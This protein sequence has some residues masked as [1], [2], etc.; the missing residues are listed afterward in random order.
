[1]QE[2]RG[3]KMPYI[4]LDKSIITSSLWLDTDATLLFIT[5]LILADLHEL[6]EP[7]PQLEINSLEDETGF[8]V[9]AGWYGLVRAAGPALVDLAKIPMKRGM[10]ALAILGSPDV[11][12]RSKKYGGRRLV[13]VE[14]GFLVLTYVEHREKDHTAAERMRR[15]RQRQVEAAGNGAKPEAQMVMEELNLTKNPRLQ[16][17]IQEAIDLFA[18]NHQV[19]TT[20]A[21]K[22]MITAYRSY[23]NV[24]QQG[25]L[26]YTWG[27]A[28]FFSEGHWMSDATWP[29]EQPRLL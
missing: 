1:M 16:K 17:T 15:Y 27:P 2:K 22:R 5:A 7:A 9:P 26:R 18:N 13:R 12:S 28:K 4:K 19:G 14:H 25:R 10:K 3:G 11:H 23:L 6:P 29:I 20:E 21:G 8:I 24:G